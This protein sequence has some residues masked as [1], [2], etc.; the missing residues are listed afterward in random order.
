MG[1]FPSGVAI[2]TTRDWDGNPRG[3]TSTAV[4]SVSAEPPLLLVSV[5]VASRTLPALRNA[6][7]FVVNIIGAGRRDLGAL[8]A[9]KEDAKFARVAWS[10]TGA[11]LPYF[12]DAV[13]WAECTTVQEIE[14]GDHVVILGR[15][16]DGEVGSLS[17]VP[18]VYC[19]RTWGAW[20]P[21][22]DE[23]R[24]EEEERTCPSTS[25]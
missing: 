5:D 23:S 22:P 16:E 14:S 15:V 7:R 18:L 10:K 9:S 19:R 11:G 17:E 24:Q 12:P 20:A 21:E 8:F 25:I 1:S 4:A 2:V 6:R 3:L 13:A